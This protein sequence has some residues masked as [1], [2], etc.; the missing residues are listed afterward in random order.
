M[1]QELAELLP[2]IL[3]IGGFFFLHLLVNGIIFFRDFFR[4]LRYI[5]LE[6]RRTSGAE[7]QYWLRR[8]RSLW[9]SLIPWIGRKFG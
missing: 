2:P 4:Q 1:S 3:L 7:Q 6:I 8:R 5:S 9:L